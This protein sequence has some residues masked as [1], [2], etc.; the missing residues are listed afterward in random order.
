M[1]RRRQGTSSLRRKR[2]QKAQAEIQRLQATVG[3][4]MHL[5]GCTIEALEYFETDDGHAELIRAGL[6]AE[7]KRITEAE[8]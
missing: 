7:Y 2:E 1:T 5:V 3:E 4:L 6:T 8:P